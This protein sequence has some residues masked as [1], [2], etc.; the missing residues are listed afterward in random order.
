MNHD[1]SSCPECGADQRFLTCADRLGLLLAW[2]VEDEALR[3]V[4]FL[5]VASYNLQHPA[6]FTHDAIAG[7]REAVCGYLDGRL[8][9]AEIRRRAGRASRILRPGGPAA[10][11]LRAW[12]MTIDVV[13]TPGNPTGAADRVRAWAAT[14]RGAAD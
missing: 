8:S 1:V 14:I 5:T 6:A 12:P 13:A 9:I 7:L 4:H 11:R 3:A 10:P 2:E